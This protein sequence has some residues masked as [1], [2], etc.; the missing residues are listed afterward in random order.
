MCEV[1]E[2]S[3]AAHARGVHVCQIRV[4]L[5]N[6]VQVLCAGVCCESRVQAATSSWRVAMCGAL[7]VW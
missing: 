3:R 5:V 1:H 2:R 7:M 6:S 4:S